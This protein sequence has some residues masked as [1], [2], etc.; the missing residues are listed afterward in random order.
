VL[1]VPS[2]ALLG[3][4][5]SPAQWTFLAARQ[6]P[7]I[8]KVELRA[9]LSTFRNA[10]DKAVEVIAFKSPVRLDVF[11]QFFF[12]FVLI[13]ISSAVRQLNHLAECCEYVWL[14]ALVHLLPPRAPILCLDPTA[15]DIRIIPIEVFGVF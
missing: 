12:D 15:P 1:A 14:V 7:R 10:I 8:A 11:P 3:I 9:R 5:V 13:I 2:P 4:T 6:Q